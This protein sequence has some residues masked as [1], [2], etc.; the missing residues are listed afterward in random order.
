MSQFWVSIYTLI[1]LWVSLSIISSVFSCF[2]RFSSLVAWWPLSC[3]WNVDT[4]LFK[5]VS[6]S[7]SS[8]SSSSF[9]HTPHTFRGPT[10]SSTEGPSG[11]ARMRHARPFRLTPHMFRGP[12]GSSTEEDIHNCGT[13]NCIWLGPSPGYFFGTCH[14]SFPHTSYGAQLMR[15]P[16]HT[17]H[18]PQHATRAERRETQDASR[19]QPSEPRAS[20]LLT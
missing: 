5:G 18:F 1:Q 2:G 3:C 19:T 6:S 20:S 7:S 14:V 17:S 11:T 15:H 13:H 4:R 16:P 10:G 9:R 8:S 12:I